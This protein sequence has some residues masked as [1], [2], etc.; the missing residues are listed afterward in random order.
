[1]SEPSREDG[2]HILANRLIASFLH[3]NNDAATNIG[4][5]AESIDRRA[6]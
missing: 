5:R 6:Q 3:A 2:A 4:I 1:M